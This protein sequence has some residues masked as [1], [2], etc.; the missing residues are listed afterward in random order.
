[1][2]DTSDRHPPGRKPKIG[3]DGGP[4]TPTLKELGLTTKEN[5][6]AQFLIKL[7]DETFEAVSPGRGKKGSGSV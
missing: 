1:M 7:P 4:I 2:L 5:S 3:H 6:Q